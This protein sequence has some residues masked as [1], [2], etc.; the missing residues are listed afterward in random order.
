MYCLVLMEKEDLETSRL[1]RLY[2]LFM[3]IRIYGIIISIS[4]RSYAQYI[5]LFTTLSLLSKE[6]L[7]NNYYGVV[8]GVLGP[9]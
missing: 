5:I 7:S 2:T 3:A 1:V 6:M 8:L 4:G 9:F